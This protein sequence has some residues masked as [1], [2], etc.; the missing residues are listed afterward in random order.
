MPPLHKYGFEASVLTAPWTPFTGRRKVAG[1]VVGNS[2][3]SSDTVTVT[4]SSGAT[5]FVFRMPA[6]GTLRYEPAE[7]VDFPSGMT[8]TASAQPGSVIVSLI[9]TRNL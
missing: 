8:F 5:L 7:P 3:A 9:S 2:N 1:I 6:T 4:D